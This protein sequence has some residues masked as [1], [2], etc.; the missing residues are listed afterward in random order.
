MLN[1]PNDLMLYHV[2]IF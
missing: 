2:R 1:N